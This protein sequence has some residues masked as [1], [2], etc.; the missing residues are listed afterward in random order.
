MTRKSRA[1]RRL[2]L[3]RQP[4]PC[5]T[6]DT[7]AHLAHDERARPLRPARAARDARGAAAVCHHERPFLFSCGDERVETR[8]EQ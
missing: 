1:C 2:P 4:A 7:R 6:L 5:L 8:A 3:K